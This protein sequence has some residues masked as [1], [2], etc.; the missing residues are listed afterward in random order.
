MRVFAL[1][2]YDEDIGEETVYVCKDIDKVERKVRDIVYDRYEES[3]ETEE[4]P[5]CID[6]V[7]RGLQGEVCALRIE[8]FETEF[9]LPK[10]W[11]LKVRWLDVWDG[12]VEEHV[13][14]SREK[15]IEK[16]VAIAKSNGYELSRESLN[17]CGMSLCKGC[18]CRIEKQK[19]DE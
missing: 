2:V 15:A 6:R 12:A 14:S 5:T 11:L 13:C 3:E 18:A 1:R 8:A 4:L 10:V 16:A 19:I 9:E 17:A 7:R